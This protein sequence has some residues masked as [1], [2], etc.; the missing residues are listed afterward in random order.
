MIL[1]KILLSLLFIVT[2]SSSG[3]AHYLWIE[4]API[5]T[6]NNEQE[7]KVY[8]GEFSLGLLEKV[9]E[10]AFTSVKGFSVWVL[11]D[12]GKKTV[13]KMSPKANYYSAFF[14]PKSE[15]TF[16]VLLD[17]NNIDVID[18]TKYDFGIFKTHYHSV[19]KIQVGKSTANTQVQNQNGI[20]IKQIATQNKEVT[21]QLVY[22]GKKLAENEVKIYVSDAW[23]KTLETD[24]EGLISFKLPWNTKYIVEATIKEEVPGEF[25][26][27]N[28]EFIWHCVSTCLAPLAK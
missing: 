2:I 28:Y 17:N 22:K 8:F 24:D 19:A 21:L 23:T 16:T 13:L 6:L 20:S 25:K 1:K 4:T 9:N 15:G 3:Y 27:K 11:D 14:T 12:Q 7:I 26:G 18:Y 10:N 5:G